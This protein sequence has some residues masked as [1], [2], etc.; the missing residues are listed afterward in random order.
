MAMADRTY[1]N[2]GLVVHEVSRLVILGFP[3]ESFV[4]RL[5][6]GFIA[7]FSSGPVAHYLTFSAA[8]T[9]EAMDGWNDGWMDGGSFK[10]RYTSLYFVMYCC[11][12]FFAVFFCPFLSVFWGM[13]R[14]L[15]FM[16]T[17]TPLFAI[18]SHFVAS[19]RSPSFY[20]QHLTP[21]PPPTPRT[22]SVPESES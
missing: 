15:E 19:S 12:L 7:G 2:G 6:A 10:F 11:C 22:G 20:T 13:Y 4:L 14:M 21:S 9:G 17:Y 16:F 5:D 3:P 8:G 18:L 1:D